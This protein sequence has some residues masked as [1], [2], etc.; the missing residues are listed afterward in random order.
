MAGAALSVKHQMDMS[1]EC[2]R[3]SRT[4]NLEPQGICAN[5]SD[6]EVARICRDLSEGNSTREF[7]GCS[8]PATPPT[9]KNGD[10]LKNCEDSENPSPD[11]EGQHEKRWGRDP[12]HPQGILVTIKLISRSLRPFCVQ[13]LES[14][15]EL[16]ED[17]LAPGA[18][19]G[20]GQVSTDA[21]TR[22]PPRRERKGHSLSQS[23]V[24]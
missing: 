21:Q 9:L 6:Q 16:S 2:S 22:T 7:A 20:E 14:T 19:R 1:N 13:N 15:H 10:N 24:S 8:R 11:L 4:E 17:Q 3:V 12:P 23:S 18:G 5:N